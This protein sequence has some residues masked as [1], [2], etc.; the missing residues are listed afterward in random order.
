MGAWMYEIDPLVFS[1]I[2]HSFVAL[3]REISN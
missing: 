2:S 1:S 3:T